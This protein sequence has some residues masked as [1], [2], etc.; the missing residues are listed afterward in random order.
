MVKKQDGD[1]SQ[2]G[3][4]DAGSVPN[5]GGI[6]VREDGAVCIGPEC[7]R[8]IIKQEGR[9][10]RIQLDRSECATDGQAALNHD[11]VDAYRKLVEDTVGHGGNTIWEVP[12]KVVHDE[13]DKRK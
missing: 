5:V 8:V 10:I 13:E 11:A 12:G 6:F 7:D 1:K 3:K 9:N 2:V 4:S